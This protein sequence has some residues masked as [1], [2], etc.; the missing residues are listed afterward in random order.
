MLHLCS[1]SVFDNLKLNR[2]NLDLFHNEIIVKA[3]Y[4][5][6]YIVVK[7]MNRYLRY[8]LDN[9]KHIEFFLKNYANVVHIDLIIG[10]GS[11]SSEIVNAVKFVL[12]NQATYRLRLPPDYLLASPL[13]T[14]INFL[15][16]SI[17]WSSFWANIS[18]F[19]YPGYQWHVDQVNTVNQEEE[20]QWIEDITI[21]FALNEY[22]NSYAE[23]DADN[24]IYSSRDH[25]S[26]IIFFNPK[27][28][29]HRIVIEKGQRT[30]LELRSFG[31]TTD[32]VS[33]AM[34]KIGGW[35]YIPKDRN[36]R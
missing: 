15:H 20:S 9:V 4:I 10:R 11:S 18:V 28:Y 21:N 36:E 12:N 35:F 33:A 23:L 2:T 27:K 16:T 7:K 1:D 3:Q 8:R 31:V 22:E 34:N 26:S 19:R 30:V 13:N 29:W 24:K 32:H 25:R 17:P 14:A 6:S 5:P